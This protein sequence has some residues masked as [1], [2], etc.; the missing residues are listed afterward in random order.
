MK[1][2]EDLKKE[3]LADGIIDAN[4]VKEL[5]TILFADGKI[6]LEEANLLFQ[7]ND[8]VSGKK[9][10]QKWKQLFIK[11][12]TSYLLEDENTP[13]EIDEKETE[14]LYNKI[15]SD[16]KIDGIEKDLLLNLKI[17]AKHF[18]VRLEELL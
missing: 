15:K 1:N 14:W 9:N 12:I 18:P 16:G 10:D 3:L 5:E 4:E 8:A 6:D 13:G 2:L 17:H 11:T 7:I